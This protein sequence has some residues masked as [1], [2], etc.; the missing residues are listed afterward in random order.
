MMFAITPDHGPSGTLVTLRV[1]G[2]IDPH[3]DSHALS[4]NAAGDLHLDIV[5]LHQH[6]PKAIASI[7]GTTNGTTLLGSFRVNYVPRPKGIFVAQCSATVAQRTF[8]VTHR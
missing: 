6:Y 2:C 4:Y 1:T 3:G 5:Q 8:T 7:P